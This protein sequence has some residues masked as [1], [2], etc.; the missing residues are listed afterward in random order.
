MEI[1]DIKLTDVKPKD[2]Y[3]L[4]FP[5]RPELYGELREKLPHFPLII[6]DSSGEV[7]FGID[8]LEYLRTQDVTEV[9]V[10]KTEVTPKEALILN[11]N[12]KDK[13]TGL[14]LYE[15]LIFIQKIRPLAELSYVYGKTEL[16]INVKPR[17]VKHLDLLLGPEFRGGL[18]AEAFSLKAALQLCGF[19]P[20]DRELLITLFSSVP[21]SSSHQLKI[22]EM[23]EEILFRDKCPLAEVF[24]K[25]DING[26]LE[27]RSMETEK[28]QKKIID[29]LFTFRNPAYVKSEASWAEEI[30]RLG[31]PG[32]IKITHF[33]FFEKRD[34][35]VT[36]RVKTKEELEN[37]IGKLK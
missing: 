12:L 28:P 6:L 29:T 18:Q 22:L 19:E 9:D 30:K 3:R 13:L 15:K 23:T 34:M 32:H 27:P 21:F 36:V 35:E 11:Y 37:L 2:T 8:Y 1:V 14:N 20:G 10:F 26:F 16:D 25:L 17:L 31:A 33:P 4:S 7:V 24:A 5:L